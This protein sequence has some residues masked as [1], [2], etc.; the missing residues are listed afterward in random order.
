MSTRATIATARPICSHS[1]NF[2]RQ[3]SG[4]GEDRHQRQQRDDRDILHQQDGESGLAVTAGDLALIPEHL[5]HEGGGRQGEA[6]PISSAV[7]QF[8]SKIRK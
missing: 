4:V 6:A 7:D 5:H 2:R 8:G 1:G 3:R